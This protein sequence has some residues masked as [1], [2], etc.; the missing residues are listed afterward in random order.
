[1]L[2]THHAIQR[3]QK[4]VAPISAVEAARS[5]SAA[6]AHARVRTTPRRWM[7]VA[8]EPGLLFLYPASLPGVCLLVR[9]GTVITVFERSQCRRW[10]QDLSPGGR[11]HGRTGAYQRPCPGK[12]LGEAA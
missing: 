10:T 5:I 11:R 4:R 8:P 3:F 1:V 7:L 6:A 9:D 12:P 2:I